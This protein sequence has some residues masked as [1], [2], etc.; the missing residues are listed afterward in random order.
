MKNQV[1]LFYD[2]ETSGLIKDYHLPS[3]DPSH[4]HITQ[5]AAM[6]RDEQGNVVARMN[7]FIRPDGW[8]LDSGIQAFNARAGNGIT[9]DRLQ[10]EGLPIAEAMAKFYMLVRQCDL[11]CQ[12]DKRFIGRM[13]R[14]EM[15][16]LAMNAEADA[17]KGYA[18]LSLNKAVTDICAIPRAK[19]GGYKAPSLPEAYQTFI[20][21]PMRV[22]NNAYLDTEALLAIYD[23]TAA[24]PRFV[25]PVEGEGEDA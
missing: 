3:E 9:Q 16:R 13:I 22:T 1:T 11:V 14:I 4:P 7:N 10:N 17:F 24:D 18:N 8:A 20:G 25:W 5:I 2:V 19:G 6:L 12:W 23:K 15:K 21:M